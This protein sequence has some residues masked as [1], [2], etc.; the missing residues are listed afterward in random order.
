MLAAEGGLVVG[1]QLF[2]G[3]D[4]LAYSVTPIG[5]PDPVVSKLLLVP[6]VADTEQE[7]S[8]GQMIERRNLLGQPDRIPLGHE[9]D[10]GANPQRG[11]RCRHRGEGHELVVAP[12]VE[13]GKWR[14]PCPTTPGGGPAGGNVRVLREPQRLEASLLGFSAQFDGLNGLV[15]REDHEAIAHARTLIGNDR[16]F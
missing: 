4:A 5:I 6:A 14:C 13:V 11:G 10:A 3:Q 15:G 8:P 2:H 16:P 1:P 9:G 12:P 7:A